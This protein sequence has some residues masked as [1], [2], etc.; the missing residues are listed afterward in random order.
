[1]DEL[2]R[3][4]AE[5]VGVSED[6]ARVAVETVVNFLKEK[7]PAPLAA[8]VDT[9]LGAAAPALANLDVA[10]LAGSLGGLFGKK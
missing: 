8:H 4:V 9:A 2:V 7:L 6:K 5:K 1:M 3:Q 10:S